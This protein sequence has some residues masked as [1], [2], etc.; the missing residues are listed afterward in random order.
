[1]QES[2]IANQFGM[3]LCS[4]ALYQLADAKNR[5]ESGRVQEREENEM[6]MIQNEVYGMRGTSLDTLH[7]TES[8]AASASGAFTTGYVQFYSTAMRNSTVTTPPDPE[9]SQREA[10]IYEYIM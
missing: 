10:P 6:E 5:V 7:E 8:A 9:S 4:V 3:H 1:M 2:H